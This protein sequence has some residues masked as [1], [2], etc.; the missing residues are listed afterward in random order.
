MALATSL[1]MARSL[2]AAAILP[3]LIR[4]Y[5]QTNYPLGSQFPPVA[6]VDA[7]FSFQFAPTTFQSD[8]D[9]LQYSLVSGPSWLSLVSKSRT[10]SG[11]PRANDA[12]EVSFAIAAAASAGVVANMGSKLIVSKDLGPKAQGNVTDVLSKAGQLSGP[13]TLSIGPSKPFNITFP[14]DSFNSGKLLSYI[15]LLSDRT[16]LPA[17]I[18]FDTSSLH[19]AGTTPPTGYTTSFEIILVAS[20]TP[21][22]AAST[23][24]F[25]IAVSNHQLLFQPFSQTFNSN[26]R[27]DVHITGLNSMLFL[28]SVAIQDQQI[29]S[30][31]AKLLSWLTFDDSTAEISGS[32]PSGTMSQDLTIT[33]KDQFGNVAQFSVH[34][35]FESKL[36]AQEIGQLNVTIGE[37]FAYT[38]P[39]E[40]FAQGDEKVS[41]D[42]AS[43]SKY[44]HFDSVTPTISGTVQEDF[45]PQ[46]VQ[47]VLAANS[48]DDYMQD[49]QTLQIVIAEPIATAPAGTKP[50][51]HHKNSN[52][53]TAGIIVGSII[54]AI[55][56]VLLLV[57]LA[58][59]LCRR[60]K[61]VSYM[62]PKPPKSP[63]KS[64]ISRP[65]FISRRPREGK[66]DPGPPVKRTPEHPPVLDVNLPD[67]QRDSHSH[68][69][70]IRDADIRILD[71]FDESSF[72]IQNDIAPSQHP[73]DS[74]K[75]PTKLA[76]RSSQKSDSFRKH[77]RRTT[78]VYQDQIH[79]SSGLP[80][81]RR[82]TGAGH[83]RHTYSPSW[84]STNFS[85]SSLHRPPSVSSYTTTRCTSTFSTAPSAFPQSPVVQQRTAVTTPTEAR[86]SMRV[87]P[88]SRRSS[89]A[90]RR[91]WDEKRNSYIRKRASAQSP[92]FSAA[93]SRIS[94][95]TYKSSPAFIAEIK[96]SPWAASIM[97][98]RDT[99]VRPDDDVIEGESREFPE[100]SHAQKLSTDAAVETPTR[101][102]LGSFRQ[103]RVLR[104]Y[105][106]MGINRDRVEKSYTRPETTINSSSASIRRRA[107]VLDSL[108]AP[109]LKSKL[110]DL[111][112]SEIF[113]DPE[114]SDSVYTDEEEDIEEAERGETIKPGQYTPPPLNVDTQ[115]RNKRDSDPTPHYLRYHNE[116]GGKENQSSTYSISLKSSAMRI[117]P[118]TKPQPLT[119]PER[120]K[121]TALHS[122][123]A[124]DARKSLHSRPQS[125]H[126]NAHPKKQR[127]RSRTQSTAYPYF[128]FSSLD[129]RPSSIGN[130]ITT[131]A[132]AAC[133]LPS[134]PTM[135][136]DVSGNLT[137]YN[138][139]EEPEIT[140]LD[141]SSIGFRTSNGRVNFAARRQSR[142]A[143]LHESSKPRV[144]SKSSK[145][146]TTV[147]FPSASPTAV[148]PAGLGFFPVDA[149]AELCR[150]EREGTPVSVGGES[151]GLVV[152]KGRQTWGSGRWVSGG[153]WSKQ[154]DD[155]KVSI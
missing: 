135:T 68:T 130:A 9:R 49:T 153:Y 14:S 27:E 8:S 47:C 54:G 143:S 1:A 16:P 34:L 85:R 79:R 124:S 57:T 80:V 11:I 119:S 116:H 123:T 115:R 22:Y 109:E 134:S 154:E 60:K 136:R 75:I 99:I 50:D 125:H 15:A 129:T 151:E 94:S 21:G 141:S 33:A 37:H 53:R 86:R 18:S 149:R 78:T 112:G 32:A 111:T 48:S 69:G 128:D 140:Q 38:L 118:H 106:S 5:L 42:F 139:D 23:I 96:T 102:F 26:E 62:S 44:L 114:L 6:H 29:Q 145:R 65:M 46:K 3:N 13:R 103:N 142:L 55:N 76:K 104:P 81:N 35:A 148:R 95:S 117:E 126:S 152:Q 147:P 92:F 58:I 70:S 131:A 20:D 4:A 93:G 28:D 52:E 17:W 43:L 137:F 120:P 51:T 61:S 24:P 39:A 72:G 122:R 83:G 59:C 73:H 31:S 108:K 146:N 67:G 2:L 90:E 36:F 107:S 82:I 105:T 132:D 30:I 45:A 56:G 127:D 100:G 144:P 150:R 25:T 110:N 71:I 97:K 66:E 77:R 12:G 7:V 91:D 101:Q 19:F 138:L 133:N 88:S 41:V 121:P 84:S 89:R 63:R 64:D 10:L 74:K 87:V 155:D 98:K 40:T 113:K